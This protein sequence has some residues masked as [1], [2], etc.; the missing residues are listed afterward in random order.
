MD[1][2]SKGIKGKRPKSRLDGGEGILYERAIAEAGHPGE[3]WLSVVDRKQIIFDLTDRVLL[4]VVD[5]AI[6]ENLPVTLDEVRSNTR[7]RPEL[8]C[9]Q[10]AALIL[11][12]E[13]PM[14][15]TEVAL[16]L[17]RENHST[18]VGYINNALSFLKSDPKFAAIY[19]RAAEAL[20]IGVHPKLNVT[21][22]EFNPKGAT[23]SVKQTWKRM[24]DEARSLLKE[25]RWEEAF[26]AAERLIEM[27]PRAEADALGIM[28]KA[29]RK[30][31][32]SRDYVR[33]MEWTPG[34]KKALESFRQRPGWASQR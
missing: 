17:G 13:T 7:R 14:P 9:R 26:E 20:D 18:V 6:A 10:V 24:L 30:M 4:A 31:S 11:R 12:Y 27:Y 15:M 33:P 21:K 22:K 5:A 16:R 19:R 34:E 1:E 3:E 23:P 25:E 8:T 32:D 28:A 29:E 2:A